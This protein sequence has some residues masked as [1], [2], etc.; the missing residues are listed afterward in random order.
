MIS[1]VLPTLS[2]ILIGYPLSEAF[3]LP[4]LGTGMLCG[5]LALIF[6]LLVGDC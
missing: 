3:D 5:G 6:Q 2:A 1:H 4:P